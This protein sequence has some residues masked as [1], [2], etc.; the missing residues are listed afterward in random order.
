MQPKTTFDI[1]TLFPDMFFG[2][3]S[4]SVLKRA[5]AK[6]ILAVNI[7]NI[8]AW[9]N[10]PHKTV[11]DSPYGGGPGMV[12]RVDVLD[13]AL[14][15]IIK[16]KS[17]SI[18]YKPRIVL[19]TPQGNTFCQLKAKKLARFPWMIIICG[20]YEGYDERIR[21]LVDEEISIGDY[22]LTG[23]ELPAMVLIDSIARLIPGV[24]G[25]EVSLH[26]ESFSTTY[27]HNLL[28]EYPHYT[29][30]E[31]YKNQRVPSVLLSGNHAEI[32]KWRRQQ[33]L[34][35]TKKRRPDLLTAQRHKNEGLTPRHK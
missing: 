30:P 3:L 21:S 34:F 13:R 27:L 11:D 32:A 8:R 23:G 33:A 22:I 24:V 28:L 31:V 26:E 15:D 4:E 14:E 35:R 7:H 29:R 17:K 6:N 16:K 10:D 20:H 1:L 5:Q 12:M 19:M 18:R 9:A 2:P 25:K